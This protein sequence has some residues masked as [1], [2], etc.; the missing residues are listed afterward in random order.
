MI[1]LFCNK[2]GMEW[3]KIS[4]VKKHLTRVETLSIENDTHNSYLLKYTYK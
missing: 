2:A 4:G 1:D 3:K